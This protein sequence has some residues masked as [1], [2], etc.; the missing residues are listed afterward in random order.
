MNDSTVN[1]GIAELQYEDR[2]QVTA[3]AI[4]FYR[5]VGTVETQLHIAVSRW[6]CRLSHA[7]V[8]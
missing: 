1:F 5:V 4:G 3:L 8:L 7:S 6:V 2:N